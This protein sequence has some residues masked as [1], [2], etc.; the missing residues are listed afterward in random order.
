MELIVGFFCIMFALGF[1]IATVVLASRKGR[2]PVNWFFLSIFWGLVGLIILACSKHVDKEKGEKDTLVKVL[3][4]I[5]LIPVVLISMFFY[6]FCARHTSYLEP[7]DII[8]DIEICDTKS[9]PETI[10]EYIEKKVDLNDYLNSSTGWDD[11]TDWN[12]TG[13]EDPE[14]M[15]V[16]DEAL[17]K[18]GIYW[19]SAKGSYVI[20]V[21]RTTFRNVPKNDSHK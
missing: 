21:K 9:E 2:N 20:K 11:E 19:S 4:V 3:W 16:F 6:T 1:S 8:T 14:G 7:N 5:T 15:A 13:F 18:N 12:C 10:V 17:K